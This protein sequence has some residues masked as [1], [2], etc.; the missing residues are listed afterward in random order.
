MKI[1]IIDKMHESIVPML[2]EHGFEVQYSPDFKREDIL[3]RI[4][5]FDGLIVRSKITIDQ[6]LLEAA[7]NLKFVARAGAGVDQVDLQALEKSGITLL[8][9]PE[10]NRDALAEHAVGMLLA[11]MNK[12][13]TADR[14]VREFIWQREQNR[15][16]ELSGKTVGV[17]GY[18][19]MGQAF[20][21]RLKGFGCHILVYDKYKK[22]FS[23]QLVKE[24]SLKQLQQEADIVSLHIPLTDETKGMVDH[25]FMHAFDKQIFL[26]NTARGEIADLD[27][28]IQTLQNGKLKG[29]ALDVLPVEKFDR[30]D[31]QTKEKYQQL[32][33]FPQ[34]LLSPHV[35]GWTFESYEKIN[36][37]LVNKIRILKAQ[38]S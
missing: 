10:G 8:N 25:D 14:E 17:I 5:A 6:T 23:D 15:G 31:S 37:T 21:Q 33:L 13:H 36:K 12:L 38:L 30:L 29:A 27:A 35:G 24:V 11:L 26:L 9:A 16:V 18:G 28:L 2:E 7:T 4:A 34:V 19:Y 22:G 3:S 1:L 32:F 20:V